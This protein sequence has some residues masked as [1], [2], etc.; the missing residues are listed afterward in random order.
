M[1]RI[2]IFALVTLTSGYVFSIRCQDFTDIC[3]EYKD[4]LMCDSSFIQALN[5]AKT[6]GT[7]DKL[8]LAE[9]LNEV[10]L[11]TYQKYLI[12]DLQA[13]VWTNELVGADG[14]GEEDESK[15]DGKD[16]VQF[17]GDFGG[18]FGN[19]SDYVYGA[20]FNDTIYQNFTDVSETNLTVLPYDEDYNYR[21]W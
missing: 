18:S 1:P 17:Y 2:Q 9:K 15:S 20:G 13:D 12:V 21:S 11:E 6:C 5:C 7:C 8:D 4:F 3:S 10:T 16:G 19:L 14:S